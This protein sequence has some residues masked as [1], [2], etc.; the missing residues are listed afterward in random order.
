MWCVCVCV[1]VAI[2]TEIARAQSETDQTLAEHGTSTDKVGKS[3]DTAVQ[4]A[5][6]EL[7]KE[8]TVQQVAPH[9][10]LPIL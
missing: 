4:D 2:S 10:L 6:K 8:Q 9:K 3:L 5:E 1:Q 7:K